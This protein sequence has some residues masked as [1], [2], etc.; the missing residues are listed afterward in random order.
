MSSFFSLVAASSSVVGWLMMSRY[1][2]MVLTKNLLKSL[3]LG[4]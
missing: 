3:V 2:S 4:R 1:F